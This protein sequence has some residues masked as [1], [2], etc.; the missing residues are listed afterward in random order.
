MP[1]CATLNASETA[2]ACFTSK[3]ASTS[4][5]MNL[6]VSKVIATIV[7]VSDVD[8]LFSLPRL[9]FDRHRYCDVDN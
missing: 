8:L 4:V 1:V 9:N 5:L 7:I 2:S 6:W 3:P